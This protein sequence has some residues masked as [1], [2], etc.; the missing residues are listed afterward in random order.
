MWWV[1]KKDQK[2]DGRKRVLKP[3]AHY[4]QI[5]SNIAMSYLPR[6]FDANFKSRN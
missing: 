2:G 3:S 5:K 4:E 6:E 1:Q